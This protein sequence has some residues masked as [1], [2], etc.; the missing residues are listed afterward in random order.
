MLFTR[1]QFLPRFSSSG[2][3]TTVL[4]E[5]AFARVIPFSSQEFAVTVG[6]SDSVF[7][8]EYLENEAN[9]RT[10]ITPSLIA[11]YTTGQGLGAKAFFRKQIG[12]LWSAVSINA[13]ATNGG[14][15]VETLSPQSA[16]QTGTPTFAARLGYELNLPSVEVKLGFSAMDGPRADQSQPGVRQKAIGADARVVFSVFELRGE[17]VRLKQDEGA[18][19]KTNGLGQHDV[20]SGF[21]V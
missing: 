7:G 3:Q 8:I 21:E 11:R 1:A 2:E 5:Q 17:M 10:G 18:G 15:L 6:K 19:D 16:S 4:V 14:T 12:P 9:L 13:S 20:V